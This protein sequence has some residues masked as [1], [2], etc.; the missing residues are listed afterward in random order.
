M[1]LLC[2]TLQ[3]ECVYT[4]YVQTGSVIKAGTD[5]K[6]SVNMGDSTGNSVWISNLRNWGIMGPDH[7]YFE[8]GN[9][10][11]FTGLGPCIESPI[12]RLNVTSDGS[13]AHHGW[14]CDQ[15]EVTSTGP[16]K[17]CSKSIFYVYRWLATDAP[18]YELS[19][20]L[21]GCKDWGNWKTGPYV[22]RKPIGYDSE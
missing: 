16:H 15:I 2:C 17:G 22:V 1:H 20:F 8:R 7:D 13:G 21:D 4:L 14:F 11:I 12:C 3:N 9:S 5:S 18:P 10:D 6:I 19:A